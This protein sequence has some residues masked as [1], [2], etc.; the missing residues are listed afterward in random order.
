MFWSNVK[1]LE[2]IT[3]CQIS[4]VINVSIRRC[5]FKVTNL[6]TLKSL[7]LFKILVHWL[8]HQTTHMEDLI[9]FVNVL[10]IHI[11]LV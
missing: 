10:N 8:C 11:P 1:N 7:K 6:V 9:G 4:V 2:H 3:Q 5:L